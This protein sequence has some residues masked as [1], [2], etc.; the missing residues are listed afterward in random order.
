[1]I[2]SVSLD[3][4]KISCSEVIARVAR[5]FTATF[6]LT[7][8]VRKR[9]SIGCRTDRNTWVRIEAR[10]VKKIDGQGWNGPECAAVLQGVTKPEW[11]QGVSWFDRDLEVMWRA[12]ET[13]LIDAPPVKWRSMTRRTVL[14][15]VPHIWAAPR[16]LP[17]SR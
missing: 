16:K 11:Y 17:T 12:A 1:M 14:G 8:E 10:P 7:T 9:R 15:V 4:R 3:L 2:I 5:A 13:Q 6:D